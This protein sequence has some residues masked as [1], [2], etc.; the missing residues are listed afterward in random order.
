MNPESSA[1]GT[2]KA[3]R[4]PPKGTLGMLIVGVVIGVGLLVGGIG[5]AFSGPVTT[6]DCNNQVMSPGET[7]TEAE[8]RNGQL[9]SS[10][11]LSYDQR[12]AQEQ[13]SQGDSPWI[14]AGIGVIV[15]GGS[16][17]GVYWWSRRRARYRQ[18][19][20]G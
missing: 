9:T 14:L 19:L 3:V 1:G 2:P 16:G 5:S 17:W 4:M 7:C 12:L 20:N 8:Y 18:A 11:T 15:L 10:Q 13:Q 6:P